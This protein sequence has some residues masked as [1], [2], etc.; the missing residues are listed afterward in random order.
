MKCWGRNEWG[1][2]GYG[3]KIDRADSEAHSLSTLPLVELGT[4][5]LAK[6]PSADCDMQF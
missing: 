4:G 2:L 1:Y 5:K 3:D 6:D